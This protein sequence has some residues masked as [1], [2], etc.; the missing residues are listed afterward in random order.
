MNTRREMFELSLPQLGPYAIDFTKNGRF[1]LLGGRKGHLALMDA[2]RMDVQME[3]CSGVCEYVGMFYDSR[4]TAIY[5]HSNYLGYQ[6]AFLGSFLG[7]R[8][9]PQERRVIGREH[10]NRNYVC[11]RESH[12]YPTPGFRGVPSRTKGARAFSFTAPFLIGVPCYCFAALGTTTTCPWTIRKTPQKLQLRETIRDV[13]T[14]HN[15][16]LVAVA[17][18]KYAYIYDNQGAEV[19]H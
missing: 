19:M 2:L 14:L 13:K 8:Y 15:E 16:N 4:I 6:K 9:F 3:V 11:S 10:S 18:K 5:A 17:Q 12:A 1:M 7:A